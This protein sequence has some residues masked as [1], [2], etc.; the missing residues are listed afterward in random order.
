[1][2][3]D[4]ADPRCMI[5]D[6]MGW[7]HGSRHHGEVP[8]TPEQ[9]AVWDQADHLYG[10]ICHNHDQGTPARN[11]AERCIYADLDR[12]AADREADRRVAEAE[13][14]AERVHAYNHGDL[15]D[16]AEFAADREAGQ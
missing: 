3:H 1:M 6:A 5:E 2:A 9:E 15:A 16:R 4:H 7:E 13:N 8:M 12:D 11:D 14:Y 10:T